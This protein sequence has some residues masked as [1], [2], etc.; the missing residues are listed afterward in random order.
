MYRTAL[1]HQTYH[2]AAAAQHKAHVATHATA[3]D[4]RPNDMKALAAVLV[5]VTCVSNTAQAKDATQL[6]P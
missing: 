3:S 2:N 1:Q 4:S 6:A 5:V